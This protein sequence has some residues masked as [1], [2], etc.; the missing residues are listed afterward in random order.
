V[1]DEEKRRGYLVTIGRETERLARLVNN[2]LDFSRLERGRRAMKPEECDLAEE[3]RRFAAMLAPRAA[4]AG[5]RLEPVIPETP[6]AVRMDRDALGQIVLNLADNAF[7]YA[8]SGG[9]LRIEL[10]AGSSD[11]CV[12][13]FLD[14]G[15]GVPE[16][17]RERIFEKF[18]RI[19]EG[20]TAEKGGAGLGLSIARQLARAM[21]GELRCLPRE[22]G[23]AEFRLELPAQGRTGN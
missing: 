7:K 15:P 12:L 6:V 13:R 19:D 8:S 16:V 11:R 9:E 20:L 17:L 2:V 5:L 3:L 4:E 22:G 23:G 1:L 21:G 18:Y 10:Q 14:R